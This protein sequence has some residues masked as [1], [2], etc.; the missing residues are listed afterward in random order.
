MRSQ[1]SFA[2]LWYM[3]IFIISFHTRKY[4]IQTHVT[5]Q[6]LKRIAN[7]ILHLEAYL[8]RNLDKNGI[9]ILIDLWMVATVTI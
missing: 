3:E 8:L 9:V 1:Y 4:E 7:K 5:S 2:R 6:G